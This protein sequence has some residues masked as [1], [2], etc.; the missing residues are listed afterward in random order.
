METLARELASARKNDV[1]ARDRCASTRN[2]AQ[3]QNHKHTEL[4]QA[5]DKSE[6]RALAL[7]R[8]LTTARETIA[9]AEEPSNAGVIAPDAA[10]PNGCLDRPIERS[11]LR[12]TSQAH[13]QLRKAAPT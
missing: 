10:S 9:S 3:K 13:C 8:E 5:L 11:T 1:V 6:K 12:L 2:A 7:E 4:K